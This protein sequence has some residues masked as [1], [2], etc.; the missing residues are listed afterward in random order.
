[1]TAEPR[2]PTP[3][4]YDAAAPTEPNDSNTHSKPDPSTASGAAPTNRNADDSA[5]KEGSSSEQNPPAERSPDTAATKTATNPPAANA[6]PPWPDTR[7][8][9]NGS[10][11]PSG[12][13]PRHENKTPHR[14]RPRR[15]ANHPRMQGRIGANA[16]PTTHAQTRPTHRKDALSQ[17]ANP[18]KGDRGTPRAL[19]G[20][21]VTD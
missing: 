20:D 11:T 19:G 7:H 4:R 18:R 3:S 14:R 8:S 1:P 10:R 12:E 6:K 16:P 15:P 5:G 2:P 9:E 13:R 17:M 21:V